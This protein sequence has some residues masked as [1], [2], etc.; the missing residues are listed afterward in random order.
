MDA[1]DYA[2]SEPGERQESAPGERDAHDAA[3]QA[4]AH[5]NPSPNPS[6][7]PSPSPSPNPNSNQ[8][9]MPLALLST[10]TVALVL[11]PAVTGTRTALR[12]RD[13]KLQV[14]GQWS[15][16]GWNWGSA[17]GDAH[18]EA[19]RLRSSLSTP[20]KRERFLTDVGMLDEEDW[21]DSKVVLALKCQRAAKRCY[22]KDYGLDKEEQ[23][24]WRALAEGMA[25]CRFEGY[26]GDI[27]LA[28]DIGER[29]GP[30]EAERLSAL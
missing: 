18:D 19:M 9:G 20:E 7:S 6:P 8:A 23:L 10:L 26:D 4:D 29:L 22:A 25:A 3:A 16:P 11:H 5:P 24:A 28:E 27:L 21:E 12:C 14:I 2:P 1:V 30:V 13:T 15:E 17:N